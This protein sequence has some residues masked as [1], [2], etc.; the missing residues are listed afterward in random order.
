M[1]INGTP[2]GD[3]IETP[4]NVESWGFFFF[5]FIV[6]PAKVKIVIIS[7]YGE[8][9]QSHDMCPVI[10]VSCLLPWLHWSY[11]AVWFGK[12][13]GF[14]CL[15]LKCE[16]SA[17]CLCSCREFTGLWPVSFFISLKLPTHLSVLSYRGGGGVFF[18]FF[19]H[20]VFFFLW[21]FLL[22]L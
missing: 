8:S 18:F 9:Y 1:F 7:T 14:Q 16:P 10:F 4:I 13:A 22:L 11:S 19:L 2:A 3:E 6:F 15:A 21:T 12:G 20:T 17:W 5:F